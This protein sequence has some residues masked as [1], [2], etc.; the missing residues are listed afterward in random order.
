VNPARPIASTHRIT[1]SSQTRAFS[2][3][4]FRNRVERQ[5]SKTSARGVT[6]PPVISGMRP[7]RGTSPIRMLHPCHPARRAF[8]PSGLRG[9]IRPAVKKWRRTT[10]GSVWRLTPAR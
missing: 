3:A 6:A 9:S 7:N 4:S 5:R 8:G 1:S 10:I 2:L